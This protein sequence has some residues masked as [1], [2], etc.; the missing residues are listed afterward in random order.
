[1]KYSFQRA[2]PLAI[3]LATVSISSAGP[4]IFQRALPTTNLNN[5]AGVNRSNAGPIQGSFGGTPFTL[6]DDFILPGTGSIVIDSI[7]VFMITNTLAGTPSSEFSQIRLFGGADNFPV[8]SP[9]TQL[10][11]TY[12]ATKV[13]YNG[14][15][16]FQSLSSSTLFSIYQL[17]FAG[18]GWTVQKNQYYDF[19]VNG[20]PIGGNTFALSVS[21]DVLGGATNP[22]APAWDGSFLFFQG[23]PL[24]LT[25]A[26]NTGTLI[27]FGKGA[28]VNVIITSGVPVPEPASFGMFAIGLGALVMRLRRK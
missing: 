20:T 5:A 26:S 23:N 15:T 24:N 3:A 16:D 10:S 4:I 28:D 25:A 11:Q 27:G 8:P 13:Q 19:A 7:S 22:G 21:N 17:T 14:A 1:M 12:T 2:L 9:L 6:G 18:L